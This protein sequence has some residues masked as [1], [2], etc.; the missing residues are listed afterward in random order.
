MH[1]E[2]LAPEECMKRMT[3][4]P[5]GVKAGYK[6]FAHFYLA[7]L[8]GGGTTTE[9]PSTQSASHSGFQRELK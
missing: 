6:A 2:R 3:F 4:L 5:H 8:Q 7:S 9:G 1:R